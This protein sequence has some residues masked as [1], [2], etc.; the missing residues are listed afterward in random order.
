MNIF[1]N[2]LYMS[3]TLS[4]VILRHGVIVCQSVVPENINETTPVSDPRD[5]NNRR[6]PI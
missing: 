2:D 4:C 1:F 6:G 5:N 3:G